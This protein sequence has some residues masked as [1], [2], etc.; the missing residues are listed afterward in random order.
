M[1]KIELLVTTLFIYANCKN[2]WF[3]DYGASKHLTFWKGIFSIFEEFALG[4]KVYIRNNNTL[5]I[6]VRKASLFLIY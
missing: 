5:N 4:R 6:Y 2:T 1:N 3:I